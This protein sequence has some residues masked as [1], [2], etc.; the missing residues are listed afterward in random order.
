MVV[1]HPEEIHYTE[2]SNGENRSG[3]LGKTLSEIEREAIVQ[4]LEDA[5]GNR[6]KAA[7]VLGIGERTIYRKLKD[8][9]LT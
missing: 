6:K 9:G 1:Y 5:R 2:A 4:A 3:F 7:K 8:Y